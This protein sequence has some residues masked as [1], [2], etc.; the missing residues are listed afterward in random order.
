[1]KAVLLLENGAS[2][3]GEH[4]GAP[5]NMSGEVGKRFWDIFKIIFFLVPYYFFL[6]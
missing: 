1:M 2:F 5:I 3:V 6:L 4:F